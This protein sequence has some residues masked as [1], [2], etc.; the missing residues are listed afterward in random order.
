MNLPKLRSSLNSKVGTSLVAFS[1]I[2][3]MF[4]PEVWA[5]PHAAHKKHIAYKKPLHAVTKK[6]APNTLS[7]LES[8]IHGKYR[9]PQHSAG[10]IAGAITKASAKFKLDR[11]VIAAIIARESSFKSSASNS[12]N[13]GLMQV[14]ASVN[15]KA[16]KKEKAAGRIKE[17][18]SNILVGSRLLR[19][20]LDTEAHGNLTAALSLYNKGCSKAHRVEKINKG[21]PY[22]KLVLAEA[23]LARNWVPEY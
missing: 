7:H 2:V 23:K 6:A 9:R 4:S 21:R 13:L 5:R 19:E 20:C 3:A 16:I 18:T 17:P 1:L 12:G 14:H 15:G 10:E 8:Y 22:A 11:Y